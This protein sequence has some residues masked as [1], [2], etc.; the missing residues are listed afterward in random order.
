MPYVHFMVEWDDGWKSPAEMP[1][2]GPPGGSFVIPISDNG[3]FEDQYQIDFVRRPLDKSYNNVQ[4]ETT[5]LSRS[6]EEFVVVIDSFEVRF[7][8][9]GRRLAY[10]GALQHP[11]FVHTLA[12]IDPVGS[13]QLDSF[14]S[15]FVLIGC[16]PFTRYKGISKGET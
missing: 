7:R 4:I 16:Y 5:H 1:E 3:R 8:T 6:E 15:N 12:E 14:I 10:N 9:T 11:D 2:T 13:G